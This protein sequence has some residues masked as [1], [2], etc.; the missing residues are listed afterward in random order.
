MYKRLIKSKHIYLLILYYQC[1]LENKNK[2]SELSLTC[3]TIFAES[4]IR[5]LD[6]N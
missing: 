3:Q 6:K 2:A 1:L 5:W 4:W